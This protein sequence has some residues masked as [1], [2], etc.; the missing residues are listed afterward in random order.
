MPK[1]QAVN[2]QEDAEIDPDSLVLS[3][4][5]FPDPDRQPALFIVP[6]PLGRCLGRRKGKEGRMG[7]IDRATRFRILMAA[8]FL[9]QYCGR[10]PPEIVLEVDHIVPRSQ[11]G[12]NRRKN[13][14][15]ACFDCNRGKRDKP[16]LF[17][18]VDRVEGSAAKIVACLT[19]ARA[20]DVLLVVEAY[21]NNSECATRKLTFRLK[22]FD[23]TLIQMVA[24][25]GLTCPVCR[26]RLSIHWVRTAEVH[27]AV[28]ERQARRS[29]NAQRYAR[30]HNGVIDFSEIDDRL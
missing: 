8:G 16:L 5:S 6:L 22:D 17:P 20:L 25:V 23:N 2:S 28:K 26:G 11:G 10:C 27:E 30:D 19:E 14:V 21:C 13:L 1:Q 4:S 3:G 18:T 24:G 7:F 9:C 29:V 15:A 12:S